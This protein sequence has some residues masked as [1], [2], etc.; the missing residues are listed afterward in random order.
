MSPGLDVAGP[1]RRAW[2]SLVAICHPRHPMPTASASAYSGLGRSQWDLVGRSIYLTGSMLPLIGC[3]H[4]G[5]RF[6]I[7]VDSYPIGLCTANIIEL[8]IA[9]LFLFLVERFPTCWLI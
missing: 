7:P 6:K 1:G 2:M 3:N 5:L 9:V 4:N 8:L